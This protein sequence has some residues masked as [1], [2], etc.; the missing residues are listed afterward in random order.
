MTWRFATGPITS[1]EGRPAHQSWTRQEEEDL[2]R[3]VEELGEVLAHT[4]RGAR[5]ER[6]RLLF[7]DQDPESVEPLTLGCS[8]RRRAS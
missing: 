2:I 4:L 5:W 3:L 7:G 6:G 1:S 8:G